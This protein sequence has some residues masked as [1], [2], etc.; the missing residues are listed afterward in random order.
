MNKIYKLVWSKTQMAFV[1]ASEAASSH[2][3]GG[4]K[5]KMAVAGALLALAS[6]NALADLTVNSGE[7]F[8]TGVPGSL[9]IYM[10]E[11]GS[12]GAGAAPANYGNVAMGCWP[13]IPM[14]SSV[15]SGV[16]L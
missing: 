7:V 15:T 6:H 9:N 12:A 2:S 13:I 3:K 5:V 1:V 11:D 14:W 8:S 16:T 10:S 4:S